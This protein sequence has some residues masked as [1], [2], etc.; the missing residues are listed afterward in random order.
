MMDISAEPFQNSQISHWNAT[1]WEKYG[2]GQAWRNKYENR[3]PYTKKRVSWTVSFLG[4]TVRIVKPV[5]LLDGWHM[6]KLLWRVFIAISVIPIAIICHDINGAVLA[7][8]MLYFPQVA[9]FYT[10]LYFLVK[11][12]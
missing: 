6:M 10:I 4:Y 5:W 8:A 9:G 11:K 1:F 12:S 7:S 2:N 3:D